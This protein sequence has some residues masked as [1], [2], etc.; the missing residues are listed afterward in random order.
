MQLKNIAFFLIFRYNNSMNIFYWFLKIVSWLPVRILYPMR[1]KNRKNFIKG[2]SI[3]IGNHQS[4]ADPILI[5]SLFWRPMNY[6]AKKE[7]FSNKPMSWF[8]KKMNCIPVDRAKVDLSSI[9][10]GL[11]VLNDD[12]TLVIFPEGT[13]KDDSFAEDIKNGTAMFAVKTGAP[14]VPMYFVKKPRM[15]HFNT[16]VIGEP[17]YLSEQVL[18][19]KTKGNIEKV[20][21]IIEEKMLEMKNIYCKNPRK[22]KKSRNEIETSGE[23]VK[24]VPQSNGQSQAQDES[25]EKEKVDILEK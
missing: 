9:K 22:R 10:T 7:L 16:L 25:I 11:R 12:K 3:V 18:T 6:M 14:I 8:M 1:V 4:N 24:E 5:W 2:K 17:I 23:V 15:F 20:S 21:L 13:R 19:D